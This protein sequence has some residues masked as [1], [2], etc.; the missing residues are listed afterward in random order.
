MLSGQATV[1]RSPVALFPLTERCRDW[2]H[3][4]KGG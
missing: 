2:W 4:G 1:P 3:W